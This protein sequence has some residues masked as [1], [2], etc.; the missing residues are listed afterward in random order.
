MR[1]LLRD[2][3][4]PELRARAGAGLAGLAGLEEGEGERRPSRGIAVARK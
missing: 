2:A 3:E 1:M 4:S